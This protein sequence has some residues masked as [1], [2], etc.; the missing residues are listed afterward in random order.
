MFRKVLG[1]KSGHAF[2]FL[3]DGEAY[4]VGDALIEHGNRSVAWNQIDYDALRRIRSFQSRRQQVPDKYIF[5]PPAGSGMVASI[6]NPI[7]RDYSFVD[8]LKPEEAAVVPMLLALEPGSIARFSARLLRSL[9]E[10]AVTASKAQLFLTTA[11]T[12]TPL[13][14]ADIKFGEDI[15]NDSGRDTRSSIGYLRPTR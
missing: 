10:R 1:V 5:A 14:G 6:I 7:K 11:A 2:D 9:I 13:A 12:S 8:L 15:R 4:I 3:Y